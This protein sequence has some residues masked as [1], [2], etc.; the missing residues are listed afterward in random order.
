MKPSLVI[1]FIALIVIGSTMADDSSAERASIREK[2]QHHGPRPRVTETKTT[3]VQRPGLTKTV[4][5][6]ETRRG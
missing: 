2:R 3:W 1:L 5:V 4:Q 6:T